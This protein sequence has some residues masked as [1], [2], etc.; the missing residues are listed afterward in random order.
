MLIEQK[1][2]IYSALFN[3]MTKW[4]DI[5]VN[6]RIATA[7]LDSADDMKQMIEE[8]GYPP[9]FYHQVENFI[10]TYQLKFEDKKDDEFFKI[11]QKRKTTRNFNPN[12]KMSFED[13]STILKYTFGVQGIRSLYE[14]NIQ[15]VKKRALL[16]EDYTQ[17][18][19]IY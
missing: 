15:S 10:K 2:H 8:N 19:Y 4:K 9:L 1:W 16:E 12:K 13:L 11:L 14:S 5:D 18:K 17:Q 3:F 6:F 7:K